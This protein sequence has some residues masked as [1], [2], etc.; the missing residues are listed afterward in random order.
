ME[1]G[2]ELTLLQLVAIASGQV[3]GAGVVTY[4]GPALAITGYSAWVAYGV[5]VLLGFI[6]IIPFIFLSSTLILQGGEYSIIEKMLGEKFAGFYIVA[7]IAQCLG[8]S[9]MGLSLGSYLNYI[10]PVDR[11]VIALIGLTFFF[12]MNLKGVNVM[13]RLQTVLTA[14]LL[15][16]MGL[17]TLYGLTRLNGQ[18]FNFGSPDFFMHGFK[19]FTSAVALYAFSTYGQYMVV[20]FGK[21]AKNPKRDIPLAILIASIIILIAYMGIALVQSGILPLSMTAGKNLIAVAQG[22]LPAPLVLLFVLGCPLMALA[23]TINSFYRARANPLA[24]AAYDGWFPKFFGRTNEE[25]VPVVFVTLI[26]LIGVIPILANMTINAITRN[27]VLVAYLLR[28]MI[29]LATL[30][31]PTVYKEQ[32]EKSI[33]HISNPLFYTII[34]LAI[35]AQFYMVYLSA[36]HLTPFMAICCIGYIIVSAFYAQ[37]RLKKGKVHIAKT[38]TFH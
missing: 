15:G 34:F 20:N 11:R 2:K 36:R 1:K 17:F 9:V 32:W 6:S 5:S 4:V 33:F 14:I 26:W 28:M 35:L 3:I 27:V 16:S 38:E 8:I 29:A 21:D 24:K 10:I 37:L 23:T 18:A 7:Y 13:A 30:K 25:N 22:I 31:L 19:G 12:L